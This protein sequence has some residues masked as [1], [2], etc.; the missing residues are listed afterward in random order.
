MPDTPSHFS[1]SSPSLSKGLPFFATLASVK[2]GVNYGP[3]INVAGLPFSWTPSGYEPS[4]GTFTFLTLSSLLAST[5]QPGIRATALDAP[6]SMLYEVGGKWG[7]SFGYV[8][9]LQ[10]ATLQAA[11]ASIAIGAEAVVPN[12]AVLGGVSRLRRGAAVWAPPAGEPIATAT[13]S[14]DA[15]PIALVTPG[16]TTLVQIWASEIV[17]DYMVPN[18]L[19]MWVSGN[20][21]VMNASGIDGAVVG[22]G[23]SGNVPSGAFAYMY[24]IA[25]TRTPTPQF[26]GIGSSIDPR[27]ATRR[28]GFFKHCDTSYATSYDQNYCGPFVSGNTKLYAMAKPSSVADQIR[29]DGAMVVSRGNL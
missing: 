12:A 10:V 14:S 17:P 11:I 13:P 21:G 2:P 27:L 18:L 7:G 6:G 23:L 8:S 26:F 19:E 3:I 5:P 4:S 25:A 9:A 28:G 22:L 15:A 24:P 16:V 20:L 1:V 29:F